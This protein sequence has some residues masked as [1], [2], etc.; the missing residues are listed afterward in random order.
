MSYQVVTTTLAAALS[1][2]GT[3]AVSYPSGTSKASFTGAGAHRISSSTG[4][5]FKYPKDFEVTL[6]LSSATITWRSATTLAVGVRINVQL[7]EV[8]DSLFPKRLNADL[9]RTNGLTLAVINLGAPIALVTNGIAQA[10]SP[11]GAGTLTLNGSLASGGTVTL[12]VPRNV[13]ADSGGADTA[14]L[15]VTGTDE[16]GNAMVESI[17][18]N[19]TTAVPG[20][21]A[22]KTITSIANDAAI[23]NGA[24]VGTGDVLGLPVAV[25]QAGMILAEMENGAAAT[26]GTFVAAATLTPTATTADVRGTYDPNSA[27][28]A[29]KVFQLVI[30]S[31]EPFDLGSDQYAG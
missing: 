29:S 25:R 14:V 23:A 21:K 7:E 27:A 5:D 15:T 17:T 1:S 20:K 13:I 10:Q 9:L 4:A 6:G 26:P 3:L 31:G 18:L 19:G 30:A 22:F 24:F 12:D 28:D 8:G 11:V 16:Y 2:G